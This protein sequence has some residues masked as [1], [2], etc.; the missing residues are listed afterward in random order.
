MLASSLFA[1]VFVQV[2][3]TFAV[4]IWLGRMRYKSIA[5]DSAPVD[6]RELALGKHS[7]SDAATQASNNFKNQFELPVLFYVGV[8]F[9]LLFRKTDV[10][11]VALAWA[12]VLSRVVHALIHLGSNKLK[13][14][15][16]AYF[17]GALCLLAFWLAL[18]VRIY[19]DGTLA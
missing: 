18:F 10:L 1:P 17:F 8:A 7:W 5:E 4:V 11:L 3:L 9:A 13:W 6:R 16:L 14:R 2:M 19:A 12:F 15:R